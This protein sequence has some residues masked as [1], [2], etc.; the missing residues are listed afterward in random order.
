VRIYVDTDAADKG[1][2]GGFAIGGYGT[3]KTKPQKLLTVSDDSVRIY[4]D[5]DVS[6]KGVKGGFAIGGFDASKAGDGR[7]RNFMNISTD[8]SGVIN[9]SQPRLLWYP[10][11]N[12]FLTGQVLILKKDSVGENSMATGFESRAKGDQS[13]AMGYRAIAR[14]NYSTAIGKNAFAGN[15]NSFAFGD[16]T[17]ALKA[18]AYAFGAGA[19]ATGT[20]SYAFGRGAIAEGIGSYAL[21]SQG[22]DSTSATTG[23]TYSKGEYSM[24]LGLGSTTIGKGAI[25]L[26]LG[27]SAEG[28]YSTAIGY[29]TKATGYGSVAM[30]YKTEASAET[31]TAIGVRTK[32]SAHS[33]TATGYA[34]QA[35]GFASVAMGYYSY[36]IAD[37]STALG[38]STNARGNGSVTM[39]EG[40]IT[41]GYLSLATGAYTTARGYYS[42]SLGYQTKTNTFSMV[43]LGRWNDTTR[44]AIDSYKT[45][46]PTDPLFVVGNGT[47]TS[48]LKN[49]FTVLKNGKVGINMASPT[50]YLDVTG[51]ARTTQ[52]TYLAIS[53]GYNVGIGTTSPVKKLQVSGTVY[54]TD[55]IYIGGTFYKTGKLNV[56][57]WQDVVAMF[58]YRGPSGGKIISFYRGN[59]GLADPPE[60]GSI[61]VSNDG[62]VSYNAF[63]GSHYGV[64]DEQI[65]EGKLVVM[66]G[67]NSRFGNN[68]GTE[69]LY[70]IS[71]SSKANDPAAMGAYLGILE[72]MKPSSSI[73][74][75]LIMAEGNGEMWIVDNSE[76]LQPGD[77]L[78]SSGVKGHAMKDKGEFAESYVIAKVAEPVDWQNVTETIDGVKHYKVSVLFT[79]FVRNNNIANQST[80][81]EE[82]K[83]KVKQLETLVQQLI[84]EK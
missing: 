1:V 37:Y 6:A 44:N 69:V 46:Y 66:N 17:R 83:E 59:A 18:D 3:A 72:S 80:E 43:A 55:T 77:F 79:S 40:T 5:E 12:A 21:G 49:A 73:N 10:L 84:E 42:A 81:V 11:K 26:G 74:P 16:G 82:L 23:F 65:E 51:T 13:Q 28:N 32:A 24:A 48:N 45:W 2:K 29:L 52:S 50:Y 41:T 39:G 14:G 70:G 34:T 27:N 19:L 33:S 63:T 61:S 71:E 53:S 9:P 76:N 78:I 8:T 58:N 62:I 64:T 15:H 20:S 35:K 67:N 4:I 25:S 75:H 36:A 56:E 60:V 54:V 22:V 68:E 31:S 30:G 38:I 57:N 47:S 7:N